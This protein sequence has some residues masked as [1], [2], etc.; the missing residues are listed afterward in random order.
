MLGR[1]FAQQPDHSMVVPTG[2]TSSQ[3]TDDVFTRSVLYGSRSY[4]EPHSYNNAKIRLLILQNNGGYYERDNYSTLFDTNPDISKDSHNLK[5]VI[6]KTF[7]NPI[8]QDFDSNEAYKIIQLDEKTTLVSLHFKKS[9]NFSIVLILPFSQIDFAIHILPIWKDIKRFL[10]LFKNSFISNHLTINQRP[11]NFIDIISIF[12]KFT[13]VLNQLLTTPRLMIGLTKKF[14]SVLF[15]WCNE[16][17]NWIE[18]KDGGRNLNSGSNFLVT[19][20]TLINEYKNQLL[21]PKKENLRIVIMT[22]NP[23][24]SQKLIFILTG[25]LDYPLNFSIISDGQKLNKKS[26]T[27]PIPKYQ[28]SL[29]SSPMLTPSSLNFNNSLRTG[30]EIPSTPSK[31]I[32]TPSVLSHSNSV[33]NLNSV[34]SLSTSLSNSYL[35]SSYFSRSYQYIT[36]WANSPLESTSSAASIKSNKTPSPALEYEE[37]P[38]TGLNS[39]PAY[40]PGPSHHIARVNSSHELIRRKS[41]LPELPKI[42]RTSSTIINNSSDHNKNKIEL[43]KLM[44]TSI[45][46]ISK[47]SINESKNVSILKVDYNNLHSTSSNI[48]NEESLPKFTGFTPLY[49]P[50]F[51]LQACQTTPDLELKVINSMKQDIIMDDFETSKTIFVS[52]R[53]REIKEISM[54]RIKLNGNN[55][56]FLTKSKKFYNLGQPID[57]QS[58]KFSQINSL[59]SEVC[60]YVH[61]YQNGINSDAILEDEEENFTNETKKKKELYRIRELLTNL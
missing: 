5:E 46:D 31:S 47:I 29:S 53:A 52:L 14:D 35:P 56:E 40:H 48:N 26:L 9:R 45:K 24:I 13:K 59:I 6:H 7:G 3:S 23:I 44:N 43:F 12:K 19:L 58:L 10:Q 61:D 25:L 11:Q 20:L 22:S 38:W 17:N 4:L 41:K 55:Y 36:N 28:H 15:S 18:I 8:Y 60:K 51:Q 57:V 1:L 33:S 37:Y 49:I 27:I 30:W 16:V 42:R 2:G 50:E 34:T 32:T 54:S 21:N 39:V